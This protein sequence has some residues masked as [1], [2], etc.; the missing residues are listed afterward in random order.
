[1]KKVLILLTALVALLAVS[2][3]LTSAQAQEHD[4]PTTGTPVT[5]TL[6]ETQI[7]SSFRVTNPA[8]RN[9][10]NVNVN[11]QSGQVTLSATYTWRSPSGVRTDNI[12]AVL[13][14]N[15]VNG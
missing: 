3:P 8:N 4:C 12:I 10:T 5:K 15:I 14:A 6:T 9:L 11:L 13:I 1:M 7:N 2:I